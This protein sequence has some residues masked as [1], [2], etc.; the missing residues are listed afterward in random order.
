MQEK[1]HLHAAETR[2]CQSALP[3][4]SLPRLNASL[5]APFQPSPQETLALMPRW[6]F[7]RAVIHRTTAGVK[8][9]LVTP[10]DE[11]APRPPLPSQSR[12]ADAQWGG[13]LAAAPLQMDP[14]ASL[15]GS[16]L[17]K[18]DLGDRVYPRGFL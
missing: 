4:F 7:A 16:F 11:G 12:G 14:S 2:L 8:L 18:D 3:R 15:C 5:I 13:G 17:Y 1:L 9:G 10:S 6:H